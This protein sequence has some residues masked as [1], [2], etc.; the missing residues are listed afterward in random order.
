M[1]RKRKPKAI[2][3]PMLVV[4]NN[5]QELEIQIRTAAQVFALGCATA[6]NYNLLADFF[7]TTA[8]GLRVKQEAGANTDAEVSA[9]RPSE[10]ALFAIHDRGTAGDGWKA[11]EQEIE[12]LKAMCNVTLAFWRRQPGSLYIAARNASRAENE[13]RRLAMTEKKAA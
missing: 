10:A 9:L 5:I 4:M 1:K 13:R 3:A 11:T 7:S 6:A 12:A 2:S 8:V